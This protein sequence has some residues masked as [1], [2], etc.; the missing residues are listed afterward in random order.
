M[1]KRFL[2]VLLVAAILLSFSFVASSLAGDLDYDES[3]LRFDENGKFKIMHLCDCQD[4]YP[5]NQ[6]MLKFMDAAIKKYNP[7]VVILGGDN[8]VSSGE[9][10]ENAIKELVSVFVKNRTYFS[11][12]FGN[13]DYETAKIGDDEWIT[14]DKQL[15]M[16]QRLGGEYCLAY[17]PKPALHGSAT[18][19][20]PV[21]SSDGKEIKFNLW[22][23][24][25]GD[26]VQD[27]N[28][29]NLGYDCVTEDQIEW[30]EDTSEKLE[31]KVGK[32]VPSF[33]FQHIVVND[34]YDALFR[35]TPVDA[36]PLSGD[37]NRSF[38]NG[39]LYSCMPK[40]ENFDGF[41]LEYPCPGY[42][43][44]GQLDAMAERG[45][46]LAVFSGHDH[47]DSYRTELNGV[48]IITTPGATFH[49]YGSDLIRGARFITVNENDP[50]AFTDEVAT[51]NGFAAQ[52]E[53]FAK[54]AGINRF[55]ASVV[56]AA[57]DFILGVAKATRVFSKAISAVSDVLK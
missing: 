17:D 20:L 3:P 23:F 25:S 48:K 55:G 46:V 4:V 33:A 2:S 57:S 39:K 37:L 13:H 43:N 10:R 45:D 30:Y 42:Y 49:S 6:K 26:Y 52:N 18:H 47:V 36:G 11:L 28:G 27:E 21:F 22:L 50:S 9:D 44:Y 19:N 56:S 35:E 32:K 40:T 8:T 16:Y 34:V 14:N 51:I 38:S 12:V 54:D 1:K 41:L 5:A 29:K 7:D 31:R 15:K 24:D 53:D